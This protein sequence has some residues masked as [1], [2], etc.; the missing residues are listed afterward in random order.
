MTLINYCD[1]SIIIIQNNGHPIFQKFKIEAMKTKYIFQFSAIII[2]TLLFTSCK[3]NGVHFCNGNDKITATSEV[4]AT[5]LNNPR[6]LK[7]GPNNQLYVAE[8]GIG[9]KTTTKCTQVVA[10]VG[11]YTGSTNGSRISRINPSGKRFT[12]VDDLPSSMTS[13]AQGSLISGVA[14]VAF[15]GQTLYAVFGGAGCS[16]GV[17]GIPNEVIRVNPNKSWD[18]VANLSNYL[19]NHPVANPEED[20]FEPDGTWYSMI[21]V[22]GDLYAVEPNHG[23]LDRISTNGKITRI[24]DVSATEGH[25][26]PTAVAF[27]NGN[28]YLGNLSTFPAMTM[29]KV[30]K[31]NMSGQIVDSVGGFNAILGLAFDESGAMYV[32]E[33][34]TNNPFP[35]PGTGDIVRV[36]QWGNKQV[37]ISGLN[38][39]TG[40]TFGPD[41]KLYVSEWG[42]GMPPGGGRILQITL[43]CDQI[44]GKMQN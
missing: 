19:M 4:F 32:L 10:P 29:S 18:M 44:H 13:A 6:G 5:G 35:T 17:V 26:V 21:N 27:N 24:I 38:L 33:N 41:G 3:K 42:F 30:Y 23:E 9:G 34:F 8:G 25:I 2:S 40:M 39:P 16:H 14:D 22:N 12:Y 28:F 11:P 1:Y 15:V 43:S 20:D 37:I 36:D 7:F 31:I